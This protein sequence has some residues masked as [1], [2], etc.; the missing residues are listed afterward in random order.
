MASKYRYIC[1]NN[2]VAYNHHFT[3]SQHHHPKQGHIREL[4]FC[5]WNPFDDSITLGG[6]DPNSGRTVAAAAT[7][8]FG[9]RRTA[10]G[11][12]AFP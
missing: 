10:S 4:A 7:D 9:C 5:P 3:T 8:K 1:F 11:F 12:R 6:P 2:L